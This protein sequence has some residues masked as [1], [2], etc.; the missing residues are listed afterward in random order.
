M[1][2]VIYTSREEIRCKEKKRRIKIGNS[3]SAALVDIV[4]RLP[5]TPA[6]VVAKGG[7]TSNDILKHG[8]DI[9]RATVEGQILPGVPVVMT[10]KSNRYPGIPYI[11]FPGNVG[12]QESLAEIYRFLK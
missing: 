2:P 1:I 4:K 12:T 11:I 9:E 6:C 8:L 10:E 3:I 7:T 5:F